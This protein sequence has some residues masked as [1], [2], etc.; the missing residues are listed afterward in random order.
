MSIQLLVGL[1]NPGKDYAN[2]RHNAGEW[3][4]ARVAQA[5]DATLKKE[6]KFHGW[7]TSTHYDNDKCHLLVPTTYMN[8]SGQSI[9]ACMKYLKLTPENILVAHDDIDLPAGVVKLKFDG[10]DGGHNGLKDTIAHLH[11]KQFYRLRI[12]V[13]RPTHHKEVVDY[14]LEAPSRADRDLIDENIEQAITVLPLLLKGEMQKAMH[15][16]HTQEKDNGA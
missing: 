2:T 11:T 5:C 15:R 10:G 7:Y 8:L 13:G 3:F 9:S 6:T 14:V 12:G 16:L 4:I 1:A